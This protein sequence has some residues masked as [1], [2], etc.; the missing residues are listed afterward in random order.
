MAYLS[1]EKL[2]ELKSRLERCGSHWTHLIREIEDILKELQSVF[3]GEP[4]EALFDSAKESMLQLKETIN[5]L[6]NL[7]EYFYTK[8]TNIQRRYLLCIRLYRRFMKKTIKF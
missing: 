4:S 6:N 3:A 2:A 5:I 1:L 7:I 8:K